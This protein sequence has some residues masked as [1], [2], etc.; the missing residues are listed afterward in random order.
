MLPHSWREGAGKTGHQ[1][2]RGNVAPKKELAEGEGG[3]GE[4]E[5]RE[6]EKLGG[7]EEKE[8]EDMKECYQEELQENFK[9]P[10]L[11]TELPSPL[12]QRQVGTHHFIPV[13]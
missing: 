8:D 5:R 12:L 6:E 13:D 11:K 7:E 10:I 9:A 1:I 4:G 2:W 3:E